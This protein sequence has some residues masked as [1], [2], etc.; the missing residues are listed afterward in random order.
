MAEVISWFGA[1]EWGRSSTAV[2]FALTVLFLGR[3]AYNQYYEADAYRQKLRPRLEIVF[4]P[5]ND[6][7]SRPYVQEI[8]FSKPIPVASQHLRSPRYIP[9]LDRRFRVGV[10]NLSDELI[11][12]VAV[13][14]AKCDPGGNLIHPGHR[15]TVMDSNPPENKRDLQPH[16]KGEPTL[17]F[18]IVSECF[19]EGTTNARDIQFCYQNIDLRADIRAVDH[20]EITLRAEGG[21]A[22]HE[23]SFLVIKRVAADGK[24]VDKLAMKPL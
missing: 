16:P 20:Y 18:D 7:D 12:N 9:M 13:V 8:H 5:E 6:V 23:A 19:P 22:S 1:A 24:S 10:R 3:F 17:F 21:G 4:L 14:L 15:L 2:F 11:P